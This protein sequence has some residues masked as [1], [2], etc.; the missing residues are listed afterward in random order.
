MY[1]TQRIGRFGGTS[2]VSDQIQNAVSSGVVRA[3]VQWNTTLIVGQ[4]PV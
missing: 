4:S 1:M 2:L 3:S